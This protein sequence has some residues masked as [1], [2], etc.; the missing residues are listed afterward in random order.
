MF[1]ILNYAEGVLR[2]IKKKKTNKKKCNQKA[3]AT[4]KKNTPGKVRQG[5]GSDVQGSRKMQDLRI[6]KHVAV[7]SFHYPRSDSFKI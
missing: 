1:L 3:K 6:D 4:K 2:D 7:G 5:G